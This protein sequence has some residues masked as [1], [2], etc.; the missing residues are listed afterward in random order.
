MKR[1]K[2]NQKPSP[3]RTYWSALNSDAVRSDP[4]L[5]EVGWLAMASQDKELMQGTYEFLLAQRSPANVR[6]E[7]KPSLWQQPTAEQLRGD[8]FIG[9][10][11]PDALPVFLSLH[12]F[13]AQS[14]MGVYGGSGAGKSWFIDYVSVQLMMKSIPVKIHD[15]LNQSASKLVSIIGANKLGVIDYRNYERNPFRD[16][17]CK[18]QRQYIM[19]ADDQLRDS[20]D[21]SPVGMRLLS[22]TC[23]E[24]LNDNQIVTIPC[25][26][27]R[28][29]NGKGQ[30]RTRES[31]LNRLCEL[32]KPGEKSFCCD[33]GFDIRKLRPKSIVSELI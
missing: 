23:D 33:R 29:E 11:V 5:E 30:H 22:K 13:G 8:I 28:L 20:F 31:I 7:Q 26:I 9:F 27:N 12:S 16:P 2:S 25:L 19:D 1:R 14:H 15:T 21:L 24:I 10:S 18:D 32:S 17:E 4:D 6:P 3:A